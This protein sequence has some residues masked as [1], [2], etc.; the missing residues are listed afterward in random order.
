MARAW[1]VTGMVA[2][3][4]LIC[5]AVGNRGCQQARR[6]YSANTIGQFGRAMHI[7]SQNN[8]GRWPDSLE[9]MLAEVIRAPRSQWDDM[10]TNPQR[11][12]M[13]PAY[14]YLKPP[15]PI[16]QIDNPGR[17]IFL[18]EAYDDWG[19]GINAGFLDG[20]IRFITDRAEFEHLLAQSR[21][22]NLQANGWEWFFRQTQ[23]GV[24]RPP[25]SPQSAP[26]EP[27]E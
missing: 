26:S 17:I 11:P 9:Q 13:K 7:Y 21:A 14:V 16:D 12:H 3:G 27:A 18:H 8:A 5:L 15:A 2:A 22:P 24:R 4:L 10:L 20:H 19:P 1:L 25:T 23:A 6:S